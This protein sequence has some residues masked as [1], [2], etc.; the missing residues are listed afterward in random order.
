MTIRRLLATAALLLGLTVPATATASATIQTV[1]QDDAAL[2]HGT[3]ESIAA[4]LDTA[5][6]A[7]FTCVRLTA[8][9]SVIAPDPDSTTAPEFD[10]DDPL[11]YP[12]GVWHNL[13]RVMRLAAERGLCRLIDIAFWAPAWAT[14]GV[15]PDGRHRT[16]I[17]PARFAR[18]ARA[19]ARRY[20][21]E[22]DPDAAA[23]EALAEDEDADDPSGAEP[24]PGGELL[25]LPGARQQ[26]EAETGA[27]DD[28]DDDGTEGVDETDVL[29]G[30]DAFT[31][32]N[33]PN[34]PGFLMPQ[35]A[36]EDGRWV[37]RSADLYRALLLAS[38]PVIAEEAPAAR[39]LVGGTS[40]MGS[41]EP[42]TGGVSPLRFLRRLA[43]VDQRLRPVRTGAC[44]DARPIPGDGWAH[45]PY[46]LRTEPEDLPAHPDFATVAA[47]PRLARLLRALVT[48]GRIAPGVAA[49]YLTE[50]GYETSPPD[51]QARFGP[52]LQADLLARAEDL[53][54][55]DPSVRMWPQFQLVDRPGDP[56]GP[57][58]RPFGDWQ[59]GLI[60]ADRRPKPALA[61]Y[62]RPAW[63]RCVRGPLGP[64]LEVRAKRRRAG[65]EARPEVA[66]PDG[67]GWRAIATAAPGADRF[68]TIA[69]L[70]AT[71]GAR[72]RV[73]WRAPGVADDVA[74]PPVPACGASRPASTPSRP[75][76]DP[77][78]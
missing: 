57:K 76:A 16:N 8:G 6:A 14:D 58:M 62:P 41:R 44:A 15:S 51:P 56:A 21:G 25:R 32:W 74:E 47:T 52:D 29:P 69:A 1:L 54:T 13:D 10:A 35:W 24:S 27:D 18:F 23:E 26:G 49:L 37:E 48:R 9:W 11:A 12:D 55:A 60:Y 17:D 73:A 63:V 42:G 33:E 53:A 30:A 61:R 78:E 31:I 38:H 43:C 39:I 71:P 46:S 34:H 36:K 4:D 3:P 22:Y 40:S 65:D 68:A 20:S 75:G 28:G 45:H 59:S 72:V 67:D 70:P 66:V 5:V 64:V 7:G 19:V 77:A 2:L 50:Y